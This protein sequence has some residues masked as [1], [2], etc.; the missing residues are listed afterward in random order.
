MLWG[1]PHNRHTAATFMIAS[2][3]DARTVADTLGHAQVAFTMQ[4][5]VHG[6]TDRQRAASDAVADLLLPS[7]RNPVEVRA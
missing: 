5:Y 7:G 1:I 2:G 6:S 4:T 3:V